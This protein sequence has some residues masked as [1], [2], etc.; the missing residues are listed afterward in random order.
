MFEQI[1]Q[2]H[3]SGSKLVVKSLCLYT[4]KHMASSSDS[5]STRPQGE[6]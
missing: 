4:S 1:G 6:G 2:R 5:L 3:V